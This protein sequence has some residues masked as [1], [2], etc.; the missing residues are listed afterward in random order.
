MT[1]L[2]RLRRRLGPPG[3]V[4]RAFFDLDTVRGLLE[5]ADACSVEADAACPR[6]GPDDAYDPLAVWCIDGDHS[7]TCPCA[8]AAAAR[9]NAL[10]TLRDLP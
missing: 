3:T 7:K 4:S 8:K 5:L 6:R 1:A 9:L 2:S 10:T